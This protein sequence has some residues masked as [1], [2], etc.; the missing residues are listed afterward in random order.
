[1][2]RCDGLRAGRR[3]QGHSRPAGRSKPGNMPR[4]P[5]FPGV[6]AHGHRRPRGRA[7]EV[8]PAGSCSA[9]DATRLRRMQPTARRRVESSSDCRGPASAGIRL[10]RGVGSRLRGGCMPDSFEVQTDRC[11][12]AGRPC[13]SATAPQIIVQEE[14]SSEYDFRVRRRRSSEGIRPGHSA[15]RRQDR[16][17][18]SRSSQPRERRAEHVRRS[19]NQGYLSGVR[20][21]AEEQA[22]DQEQGGS[23]P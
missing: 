1:M 11:L 21:P 6:G 5:P 14:L 23:R 10:L 15:R 19:L 4:N 18:T 13:R 22:D 8:K 16:L 9:S 17:R 12:A 2:K 7:G 20:S 3:A